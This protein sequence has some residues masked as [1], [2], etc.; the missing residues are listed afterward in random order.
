MNNRGINSIFNH[1]LMLV[2]ALYDRLSKMDGVILYTERP[3]APY[4][5]PVLSFNVKDKDSE[6]V[7]KKLNDFG[8]AVRAGLHCSPA[9]HSFMGTLRRGAVRVGPSAFSNMN[10]INTFV[11][12]LMKTLVK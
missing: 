4:Y 8:I 1:E 3:S 10:E 2:Q 9:A 11:L 7:C 5:V 12:A 6:E